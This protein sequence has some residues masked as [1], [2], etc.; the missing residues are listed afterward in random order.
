M[1]F[2]PASLLVSLLVSS[3]GFVGFVYGKRQSRAVHMVAGA[4]LMI[5]PYFVPNV[6]LMG[7]IGVGLIGLWVLAVRLG[8]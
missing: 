3:V 4:I 5:Y 2:D 7:G 1:S 8:A 6:W